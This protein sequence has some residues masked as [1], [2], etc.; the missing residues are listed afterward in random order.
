MKNDKWVKRWIVRSASGGNP[1]VVAIDD[2][3]VYGCDCIGWTRHMPRRDCSHI[4][5][6]K[7]GGGE[8]ME[9]H[10]LNLLAR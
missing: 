10:I 2:N 5:I 9:D 4:R 8:T 3:E 7:N 6:V 1:H